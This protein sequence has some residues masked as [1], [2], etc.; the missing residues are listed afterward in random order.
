[1]KPTPREIEALIE[2]AREVEEEALAQIGYD[3]SDE[4]IALI[5]IMAKALIPFEEEV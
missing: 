3:A 2:A 1:M 4:L 5:R